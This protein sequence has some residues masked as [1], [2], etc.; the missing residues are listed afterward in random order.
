M[1]WFSGSL[2]NAVEIMTTEKI[3]QIEI[4]LKAENKKP[5]IEIKW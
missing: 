4:G 1:P 2:S 5:W 3:Q